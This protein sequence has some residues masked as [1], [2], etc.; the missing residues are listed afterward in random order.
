MSFEKSSFFGNFG[1]FVW[2]LEMSFRGVGCI[3]YEMVAGRPFFPGSSA[4]EQL[5]FI[6]RAL[7]TPKPDS[8]PSLCESNEFK[9]HFSEQLF[10]RRLYPIQYFPVKF[11]IVFYY[12]LES[13]SCLKGNCFQRRNSVFT[14]EMW[15]IFV[16]GS[17]YALLICGSRLMHF[18]NIMP[19][20]W[21]IMR[22]DWMG[23][24]WIWC[25]VCCRYV[26]NKVF[27]KKN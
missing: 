21:S 18:Q 5:H 8:H 23:T 27:F 11:N 16:V 25:R 12:K 26:C 19:S 14:F 1:K 3:L 13:C 10:N 17:L 4:E 20:H 6:F 2:L 7:G 9:V 15:Q 24:V 22:R